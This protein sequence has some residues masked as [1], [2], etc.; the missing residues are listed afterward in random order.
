M[1]H[2]FIDRYS[3]NKSIISR[4]PVL[5]KFVALLAVLFLIVIMQ[6]KFLFV[7][8]SLLIII[9][10]LSRVPFK[11]FFMRILIVLPFIALVGFAVLISPKLRW[12]NMIITVFKSLCSIGYLLLFALTTKFTEFTKFLRKIRIPNI[13]I[14]LLNFLY[15]YFFILTNEYE[16][17]ERAFLMRRGKSSGI[18]NLKIYFSIAGS[19]LIRSYE[20]SY[21]I[22]YAMLMKGYR[23]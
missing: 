21:R 8:F 3:D 4:I 18:N 6:D 10:I 16:R 14:H 7:F 23:I 1:K 17:M 12:D 15:R 2:H 20:R 13:F 11:Y 22:F 5:V 19:L 9:F